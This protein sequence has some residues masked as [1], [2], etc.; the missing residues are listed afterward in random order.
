MIDTQAKTGIVLVYDAA[1]WT[2]H[3]RGKKLLCFDG[4]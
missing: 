2:T 4:Y 1:F 3:G